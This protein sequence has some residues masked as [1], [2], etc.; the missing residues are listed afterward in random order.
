MSTSVPRRVLYVLAGV[1]ALIA[2]VVSVSLYRTWRELDTVDIDRDPVAAEQPV[3]DGEQEPD[4]PDVTAV[5]EFRLPPVPSAADGV[6]TV[7][8]LGSDSRD[9]LDDLENFGEFEGERA[10]V[11]M[12]LIRNREDG[13][14]GILSFPRDLWVS[15]PCGQARLNDILMGCNGMNG[16]TTMVVTVESLTGLGIDHFGLVDLAGFEEVVDILGGYEV[17]VDAA[18]R[19]AKS[20]LD[21]PAGCTMADGPETLAWLR[22]RNT[23]VQQDD[24]SFTIMPG[25]SDLTRNERQREF[26]VEMISRIGDFGNPQDALAS[27]RAIASFITVDSELGVPTAVSLA[28]TM[29][30]LGVSVEE[31]TIP[32][33]DYVT[34]AGAEVLIPVADIEELIA[35]LIAVETVGGDGIIGN[36]G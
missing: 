13:Q 26:M 1:A 17:C 14:A 23:Q 4:S 12:L 18:V 22:S 7:L 36:A 34:Q 19:D 33:E 10:D 20:G 32:V 31:I 16:E 30:D 5:P 15:T 25:V 27:A 21:L 3:D 2:V 29:R 35:D 8:I 6:D 9:E 11:I 28:W 24:G